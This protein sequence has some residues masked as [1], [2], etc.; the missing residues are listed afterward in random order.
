MLD[1]KVKPCLIFTMSA[2]SISPR[3]ALELAKKTAGSNKALAYLIGVSPQALSQ[4]DEV[5]PLRVIAVEKAT[6]VSRSLLRPDLYP[7]QEHAA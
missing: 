7:A 4:W 3:E 5:P 2:T 1:F 6:G